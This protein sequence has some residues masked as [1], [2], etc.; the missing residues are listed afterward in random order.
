[1]GGFEEPSRAAPVCYGAV[2]GTKWGSIWAVRSTP[3]ARLPQAAALRRWNSTV[4]RC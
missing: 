1:M 3:A 2:A 4:D